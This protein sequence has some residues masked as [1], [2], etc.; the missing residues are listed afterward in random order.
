M[1]IDSSFII[2]VL[3]PANWFAICWSLPIVAAGPDR[4]AM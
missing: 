2:N 4:G 1:A 3:F